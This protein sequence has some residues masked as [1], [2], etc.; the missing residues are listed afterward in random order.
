MAVSAIRNWWNTHR[1]DKLDT[2]D[3]KDNEEELARRRLL[4]L[5]LNQTLRTRQLLIDFDTDRPTLRLR[6]PL[7]LVNF[8]SIPHPRWPIECEVISDT[9]HHIEW[10]PPE[11]E[12]FYQPTG[13][14]RTPMPAEEGKGKVVY[15]VDH[16]TKRPY[17]TFSRVGGSSGPVK[18]AAYDFHETDLTLEF[19]S[20][21]E[22]GN[23]QKA[24]QVGVYNYELT[25]CTDMYTRKHTQW[26]YFRVRNMKAGVTYRFTV[27][28]MMKSRSLYSLGMRPLL[29]SE[30]AAKEEG[31]GWQR[32]GSNIKYYRN[33]NQNSKDNSSNPVT[34]YSLTWTLQ[35][36]YDAD[37][38][39][40]AHCYPYTYSHLQS[41]L[42]RISSNP[43]TASYCTLRVLCH[44]L[45]GNDVY[46]LTITSRGVRR[47]EARTKKSVVVTARVHPGETNASW[48]MEGFLDFLLG[49]SEDAQLLRDTFVFKVVP[50]LNPDGVVVGNYRC[51][52]AGRDLNRNYK[53]LLKDSFPCVWHTR[54]MVERL[55]AETD[56]ILYC[57]FH[58]HNRKNN[59]FM[60]GCNKRG[61]GSLKLHERVFPLMLSKNA[62]NEFSFKSC[63]F[64]VQKSKEGTGRIAMWRLGI[65]NSYTMEAS[66]GGST[67]GDRKG[68]HFTTGDLKS[69][70]FSFCDTLLDYCD[71]DPTKVT[72]CLTEL[73][74][75]LRKEVRERLG[76]DLGTN[77]NISVSD[78]ETSTSGSDS[79]DSDGLPVH[80][81]N[82]LQAAN[83]E[84]TPVKKKKKRL[85][86]HK[87]R[88][89]LRHEKV[90]KNSPPK[91]LQSSIKNIEPNLP[92]E[93]TVNESIQ[94]RPVGRYRK[95][96]QV[97]GPI[98]QAVIPPPTTQPGEVSQVTLWQGCE[99]VKDHILENMKA[100]NQRCRTKACPHHSIYTALT[101]HTD[102]LG[103]ESG[104]WRCSSQ[105]LYLSAIQPPSLNPQQLHCPRQS[106]VSNKVCRGLPASFRPQRSPISM[107]V[108]MIPDIV[109][110]KCLM[111]SF[112]PDKSNSRHIPRDRSS[113]RVSEHYF[114]PEDSSTSHTDT[115][116]TKQQDVEQ[117]EEFS[118]VGSSLWRHVLLGEQNQR[119]QTPDVAL[120]ETE[121]PGNSFVPV[122][123]S[124]DLRRNGLH[125]ETSGNKRH[126]GVL[127]PVMKKEHP[128]PQSDTLARRQAKDTR[129]HHERGG[130]ISQEAT[131]QYIEPSQC[132]SYQL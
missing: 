67:L 27:I 89:R 85:K 28:N 45:A 90:K 75:L 110:T 63:K 37:T 121:S 36:P 70:G 66:F 52:L 60:Y 72:Y 24:V 93:N 115:A 81:L 57:D 65:K 47:V 98:R 53:T 19:E 17:F 20:R 71:P 3:S 116:K 30:R 76:K 10:D 31:V 129:R 132:G 15:C 59:V 34:L 109:P 124:R 120:R 119:N 26:F 104:H 128:P 54:N 40:L 131:H 122:K 5:N 125:K 101:P 61:D 55:V 16:A 96:H 29:Y 51:S 106:M 95:K 18:S 58:G 64:R 91:V 21:F 99:P 102:D 82:Q 25:L 32:T 114:V 100:A 13:Y 126:M 22:S 130:Q 41:Y 92:D 112:T 83:S 68:T 50:M 46:L 86:S 48:M 111:S 33:F 79:S 84:Q 44:S 42:K 88:N 12:S 62:S 118:E 127:S 108:K 8:P 9:I 7:E 77:C 117:E 69:I 97:K 11:P 43:A 103:M 39:Y 56:V 4:S 1:L 23:L 49:D 73:G 78:L 80:L 6:A 14:E 113:S 87:E 74:A 94:E 35:F 107:H 105:L 123:R 38:C 2:S